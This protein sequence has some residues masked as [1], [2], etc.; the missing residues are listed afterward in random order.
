[1]A[2]E[3]QVRAA[4]NFKKEGGQWGIRIDRT[5]FVSCAI[6]LKISRVDSFGYC[7]DRIYEQIKFD[8]DSS[9]RWG[10][11]NYFADRIKPLSQHANVIDL[12][13][14]VDDNPNQYGKALINYAIDAGAVNISTNFS[15]SQFPNGEEQDDIKLNNTTTFHRFKTLEGED[16]NGDKVDY[17][18]D[19][20]T[21]DN[22]PS[23]EDI[24]PDAANDGATFPKKLIFSDDD[25]DDAN[26]TLILDSPN[27]AIK[28]TPSA[29]RV[30]MITKN[31]NYK[32]KDISDGGT[33]YISRFLVPG[34][35]TFHSIIHEGSNKKIEKIST[36]REGNP[37]P[38]SK[39]A[40]HIP[41]SCEGD[42][43]LNTIIEIDC[44]H[45][46]IFEG[47]PP[48]GEPEAPAPDPIDPP[49]VNTVHVGGPC[50]TD[51]PWSPHVNEPVTCAPA[52]SNDTTDESLGGLILRKDSS[53][54][55]KLKLTFGDLSGAGNPIRRQLGLFDFPFDRS[56]KNK[57]ITIKID[58]SRSAVYAQS[59]A[60]TASCSDIKQGNDLNNSGSPYSRPKL[61]Y[62]TGFSSN[63][64]TNFTIYNI[65]GGSTLQLDFDST[66]EAAPTRTR[67]LDETVTS[68]L[69]GPVD[70]VIT[71]TLT[72]TCIP[73][74][75]ITE[76]YSPWPPCPEEVYV[77]KSGGTTATA[78]YSDGAPD[79]ANDQFI[80]ITLLAVRESVD[81][82]ENN[83]IGIREELNNKI[84]L[85][86]GS[87]AS[88][89][90]FNG[91]NGL[92]L[93]DYHEHDALL[94]FRNPINSTSLT[95]L[96]TGGTGISEF[97]GHSGAKY[98]G[99]IDTA[100]SN[101]S[102][103]PINLSQP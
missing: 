11:A 69:S 7:K 21:S 42:G 23:R 17:V 3:E 90:N 1:M 66:P 77:T 33:V 97:K 52:P 103:L 68:T 15:N 99:T 35:K 34:L 28:T 63:A 44:I 80:T 49:D 79:G 89:N 40:L 6:D 78:A 73:P 24:R 30:E 2:T 59:F 101:A 9:G 92:S 19:P 26:A 60:I 48:P 85:T 72:T 47:E 74:G 94:R 41:D 96:P 46:I 64:S 14:I 13:G 50:P 8:T 62:N 67:Y 76:S 54:P 81:G 58:W 4:I 12:K 51:P 37:F 88:A 95:G 93:A 27:I 86:S 70:N 45:T 29:T 10:I 55:K 61:T 71:Q 31:G 38:Y 65:D 75:G 102:S 91:V 43:L 83:A 18:S 20:I 57:L 87:A 100:V 36:N 98:P 25:G 32:G 82:S 84:W 22:S 53:D 39:N 5:D 56:L 16:K